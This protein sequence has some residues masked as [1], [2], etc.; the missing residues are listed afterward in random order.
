[1]AP[2]RA[3]LAGLLRPA[4]LQL[5]QVSVLFVDVVGSTALVQGLTAKDALDLLGGALQRMCWASWASR[6]RALLLGFSAVSS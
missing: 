6:L 2:L 4:G 3:R 5:R 1:M